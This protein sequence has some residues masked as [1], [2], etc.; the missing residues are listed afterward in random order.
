M[1]EKLAQ[2]DIDS[3]LAQIP[4]WSQV[5]DSISRTFQFK[6]F[7]PAIRF[8][9][10][11]ADH[12]ESVQHHPDMLVRYNRVT[13][14]LSTHDA[15]GLSEKDFTFAAAADSLAEQSAS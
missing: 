9:N 3:R 15:N 11:L 4:D 14:T 7:L 2:P 6:D 5:G 10:L 1:V 8:V 12:A 13:L